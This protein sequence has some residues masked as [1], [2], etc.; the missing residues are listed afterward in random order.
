MNL[1]FIETHTFKQERETWLDDDEFQQLQE[2][3][4]ANPEAGDIMVGTGGCRKLRW[5]RQGTGKSGGYRVIYLYRH[6]TD[7]LFFMLIYPKNQQENLTDAQKN[8]LKQIVSQ[9]Q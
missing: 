5:R 1:M 2:Y 9:M 6:H 3:L 4:L 8:A 7:K